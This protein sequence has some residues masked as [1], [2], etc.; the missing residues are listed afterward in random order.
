V[1]GNNREF[2]RRALFWPENSK[3]NQRLVGKLPWRFKREFLH[4]NRELFAP[5]RE[6][7]GNRLQGGGLGPR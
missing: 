1:P 7:S 6:L 3:S 4:P 2:F 5:N